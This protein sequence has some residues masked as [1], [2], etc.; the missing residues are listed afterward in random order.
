MHCFLY[1]TLVMSIYVKIYPDTYAINSVLPLKPGV[2]VLLAK[3]RMERL[4]SQ[5]LEW[6][7]F[8]PVDSPTKHTLRPCS[9]IHVP[10]GLDGT[11][12]N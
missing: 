10:H 2:T 5:K 4:N 9:V 3:H 11:G 6:S 12:K 7:R 1:I 8:I